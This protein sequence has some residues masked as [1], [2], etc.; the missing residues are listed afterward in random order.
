M[1][2]KN[3]TLTIKNIKRIFI[4]KK[5][6]FK[7]LLLLLLRY[8]DVTRVCYDITCSFY[9]P[10]CFPPRFTTSSKKSIATRSDFMHLDVIIFWRI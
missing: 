10:F 7:L 6:I 1:L 9:F 3:I 8:L 2:Q 4:R 5:I